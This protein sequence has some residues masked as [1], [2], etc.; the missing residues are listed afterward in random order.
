MKLTNILVP[1]IKEEL[2]L[3]INWIHNCPSLCKEKE[4]EKELNLHL[5]L[6]KKWSDYDKKLISKH[7]KKSK[8]KNLKV[9]FHSVGMS[10]TESVYMKVKKIN[11][12]SCREILDNQQSPNINN[13]F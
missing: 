13:S 1:F 3:L 11:G 12:I 6:D 8:L 7:I 9:F 10:D 5:S 2:Y 4:K